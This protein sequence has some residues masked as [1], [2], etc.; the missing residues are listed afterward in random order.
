MRLTEHVLIVGAG[1]QAHAVADVLLFLADQGRPV[2][3]AGFVD[4]DPS[5]H[6]RRIY[7]LPVHGPLDA[8]PTIPHDCL[9]MGI[10][11]NSTRRQIYDRLCAA[12]ETFT[13][14]IHP[15]VVLSRDVIVGPG[16][17]VGAYAVASVQ[18]EIGAN[19]I[20]NGTSCLGH[21]NRIGNHCHIAPGVTTTGHVS[22]GEGAMLGVG[23]K[24]LPGVSIGAWS[25]VGGGALVREDVPERTTVVGVPARPMNKE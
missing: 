13:Q 1:A 22:L 2:A 8:I 3:V 18:T 17:Y 23:A 9:M 20:F 6:G 16:S 11:R 12:G 5:L 19:V 14:V 7:G 4:D 10:G 25:V 15:S 24:V 21:H